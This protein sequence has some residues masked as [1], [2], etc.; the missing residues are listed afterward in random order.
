MSGDEAEIARQNSM[1]IA[2]ALHI[3][4]NQSPVSGPTERRFHALLYEASKTP[5]AEVYRRLEGLTRHIP[6]HRRD[7]ELCLVLLNRLWILPPGSRVERDVVQLIRGSYVRCERRSY[8]KIL[9]E[10]LREHQWSS[11]PVVRRAVCQIRVVEPVDS[12]EIKLL[13]EGGGFPDLRLAVAERVLHHRQ[14]EHLEVILDYMVSVVKSLEAEDES[15]RLGVKELFR[16]LQELPLELTVVP[17]YQRYVRHFEEREVRGLLMRALS[18]Y[19]DALVPMLVELYANQAA[20]RQ[21]IRRLLRQMVSY[22]NLPALRALG[23]MVIAS[24]TGN[25]I[26]DASRALLEAAREQSAG[27]HANERSQQIRE[28]LEAL[29]QRLGSSPLPLLR[30]LAENLKALDWEAGIPQELVERALAGLESS[31]ER[32][33]LR[34][35]SSRTYHILASAAGSRD[36]TVEERVRAINVIARLYTKQH[37]KDACQLMWRL[38]VQESDDKLRC[39]ALRCIAGLKQLWPE[40]DSRR[41]FEDYRGGSALLRTTIIE[42]WPALFPGALQPDLSPSSGQGE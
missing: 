9:V 31:D 23:E 22:G 12:E 17:L 21:P 24:G 20:S 41:L 11:F 7:L 5:D 8:R 38:Y 33:R 16:Q 32:N 6:P 1:R 14:R 2:K 13:S 25:E 26:G 40:V 35:G 15:E 34:F 28:E 19:G 18:V 30:S 29:C 3:R 4:H 42:A 39:G 36:R 10:E 27:N 37:R